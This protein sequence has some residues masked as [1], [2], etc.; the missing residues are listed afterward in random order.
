[1]KIESTNTRRRRDGHSTEFGMYIRDLEEINSYKWFRNTNID[2][3]Y[4][5]SIIGKFYLLEEK[6]YNST[7]YNHGSDI[8]NGF[9]FISKMAEIAS[10]TDEFQKWFYINNYGKEM[11]FKGFYVI[12]FEK[13][14]P[15]DGITYL[16]TLDE[17]V[18]G[19]KTTINRT[20][21]IKFFSFDDQWKNERGNVD[22]EIDSEYMIDILS[23][24][25]DTLSEEIERLKKYRD[26][27]QDI[28]L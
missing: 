2:Y 4:W 25:I 13:T 7:I 12:V 26:H 14:C 10:K 5:N 19:I 20:G 22:S 23:H 16:N 17:H 9:N 28:Q 24:N 27:F 11:V 6:R 1:M 15:A 21:L 8:Y 3:F 18:H